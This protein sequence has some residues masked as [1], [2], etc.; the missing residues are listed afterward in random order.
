MRTRFTVTV[1]VDYDPS[2]MPE[3]NPA[4]IV[5]DEIKSNLQSVDYVTACEVTPHSHRAESHGRGRGR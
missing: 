1:T 3:G 2:A 5:R 4:D